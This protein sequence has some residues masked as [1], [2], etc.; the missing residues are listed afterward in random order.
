MNGLDR[1]SVS[2]VG[3]QLALQG[4]TNSIDTEVEYPAGWPTVSFAMTSIKFLTYN[5]W[6]SEHVAVYRRIRAIC[7]FVE[8]HD[9]DDIFLQVIRRQRSNS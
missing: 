2:T 7:E 1:S 5:V 9:P 8:R 3:W 6:S 4:Y